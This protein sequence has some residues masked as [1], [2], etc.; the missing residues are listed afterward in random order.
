MKWFCKHDWS[1]WGIIIPEYSG[2]K[3]Q[4]RKCVKCNMLKY[5]KLGYCGGSQ[6]SKIN[7]DTGQANETDN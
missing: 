4:W 5:R 1:A 7:N 2:G 6:P 3:Q